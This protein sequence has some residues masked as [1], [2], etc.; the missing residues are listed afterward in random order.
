MTGMNDEAGRFIDNKQILVFIDDI[1]GDIFRRDGEVMRLVIEQHLDDIAGF[2]AV[3]RGD[4]RT[5]DPHISCIRSRLDAVSACVGHVLGEVFVDS[6]LALAL[7]D[8]AAPALK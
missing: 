4:R 2:D 7:I 1:E 8:L 5:V 6:L 3:V